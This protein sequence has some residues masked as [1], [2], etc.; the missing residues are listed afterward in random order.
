[1]CY[2]AKFVETISHIIASNLLKQGKPQLNLLDKTVITKW[3]TNQFI[4]NHGI[5]MVVIVYEL[6]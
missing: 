5:S 2:I 4:P 6:S 1:M 3:V